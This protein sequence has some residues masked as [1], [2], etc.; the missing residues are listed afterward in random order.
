MAAERPRVF[1]RINE[2]PAS[3]DETFGDLAGE[4]A[5]PDQLLEGSEHEDGRHP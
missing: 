2:L 1:R 3:G 5:R 4:F